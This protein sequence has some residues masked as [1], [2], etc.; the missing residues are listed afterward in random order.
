MTKTLKRILN[1]GADKCLTLDVQDPGLILS[2]NNNGIQTKK[3]DLHVHSRYSEH[4]D[5]WFLQRLGAAESY[6]DPETVYRLAKEK[7]MDYVTIT[8]HNRIQG[9]LLLKERYPNE[10]IVGVES[11]A[12]F[13]EDKCKIHILL[14]GITPEHFEVVQKIRTDIYQLRDYLLDEGIVHSVAHATYADNGRLKMHHLERLILL[15]NVFESING[16]RNRMNNQGWT[17]TIK[18]LRPQH[19]EEFFSRHRIEPRGEDPWIKGL[20][21]GSD[22]H[23]G[24]FIA[25][26]YT[27]VETVS[28]EGFI[29]G[30][31]A[32]Q[33]E[34]HGRNN[35]FQ[36]LVFSIYKV[37]YDFSREKGK[38]FA[39]SPI[40]L[41][42]ESIFENRTMPVSSRIKM[43]GMRALTS[44]KKKG[45]GDLH[46][47]LN[48]LVEAA[49]EERPTYE[50]LDHL[51]KSITAT[52]DELTVRLLE[53]VK[54]DLGQGDILSLFGTVSSALPGMFLSAPF[55]TSFSHL[56]RSRELIDALC[57]KFG[58]NGRG[59]KVLW[60]SDTINDL[61]G[62][63]VTLQNFG[64]MTHAKDRDVRIVT[65]MNP[66]E[67]GRLNAPYI[68]N[69]PPIYTF[70][71]P[72]YEGQLLKV[73][74]ILGTLEKLYHEEPDE[75]LISTPGPVGLLGL[76]LARLM[77]VPAVGIYHTDF[78]AQASQIT[79]NE[80]VSD[81]L[82]GYSKWFYSQMDTV[83]VPTNEYTEILAS[84]GIDRKKM[85]PFHRGVDADIF[86]PRPLEEA[87]FC[88]KFSI[89]PGINL[90]YVGRIS[91]DKNLDFLLDVYREL[92]IHRRNIN[93]ILAGDGPHRGE[94][95]R[96]QAEFPRMKLLGR[97]EQADLSEIYSSCDFLVFPSTTD[98]F[99][100][101]VA[102]ALACALPVI[103]SD[104]G[105]PQELFE[106]G[107]AGLVLRAD[108]FQAWVNG[109]SDL[110]METRR[111]PEQHLEM[112]LAARRA[113]LQRNDWERFIDDIVSER[114]DD[115]RMIATA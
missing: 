71:L 5:E 80:S 100:M 115:L 75:I 109:L 104:V 63:S 55:F 43:N 19:I 46:E 65:S 85:R 36:G 64:R 78:A 107:K 32:R 51:F 90:L 103:V 87:Q 106:P 17:D 14:Y 45:N 41:I 50:K 96:R 79:D 69:L 76:L 112:Q 83:L 93:L 82:A 81:L 13:P 8:D 34:P 42:T 26:T 72:Y 102:E 18:K 37:A 74:S 62:V 20:T 23:A 28:M 60:F 7:G 39:A 21:A 44:R 108:D 110:I 22:D 68:L 88:K 16:G 1:N 40:G 31:G 113:S 25:E 4:P 56:F 105:G 67:H 48:T 66:A 35:T 114:V 61:N 99:G 11:T 24:I 58:G 49:R 10:V 27:S 33:G 57:R 9:A 54:N 47:L 101:V 95:E 84:R 3:A 92:L 98:T 111:D 30:I 89:E 6:T 53:S 94:L 59:K 86:H 77:S 12:Y 91:K 15:F 29:R 70:N 2:S 73:P 52:T 38:G 97:V